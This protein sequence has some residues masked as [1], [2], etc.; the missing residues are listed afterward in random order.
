[1]T[2]RGSSSTSTISICQTGCDF[3]LSFENLPSHE[4]VIGIQPPHFP[5]LPTTRHIHLFLSQT[6]SQ[7]HTHLPLSR[8]QKI[9][10]QEFRLSEV[11][12]LRLRIRF[13]RQELSCVHSDDFGSFL[14]TWVFFFNVSRRSSLHIFFFYRLPKRH[15]MCAQ[16]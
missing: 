6:V 15:M 8:L 3:V 12:V 13:V 10:Y 4:E 2:I 11:H 16:F 5:R 1:M 14:L 7:D 9:P